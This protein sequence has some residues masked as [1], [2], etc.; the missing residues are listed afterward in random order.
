MFK[1]HQ[2]GIY[3]NRHMPTRKWRRTG[4]N[5]FIMETRSPQDSNHDP[6]ASA[7]EVSRLQKLNN[8]LEDSIAQRT[9]SLRLSQ[10][11]LLDLIESV[12][13]SIFTTDRA[14]RIL[15][16]NQATFEILGYTPSE[17]IGQRFTR[18]LASGFKAF[19]D[20]IKEAAK[21]R[22]V[23]LYA[24]VQVVH[25]DGTTRWIGQNVRFN[26]FEGKL[27]KVQV[28]G[29]D[30]TAQREFDSK[31][32]GSEEKYRGI[33]ENMELGLLEVDMHGIVVRA[34]DH[35]CEMLGYSEEELIGRDPAD[36]LL[37]TKEQ[38]E[39]GGRINERAVGKGGLYEANVLTKSGE[40]KC[41][42]ISAAPVLGTNGEVVGS[43]GIHCDI[44]ARKKNEDALDQARREALAARDAE[45]DFL[46]KMSHEIRTPMNAVVGMAHLLK[47]TGLNKEQREYTEA[48]L[49]AANLLQGLLNSVLDLSKID[50]GA[51]QCK[52]RSGSFQNTLLEVYD[53]FRFILREK[54]VELSL[55]VD[56]ALPGLLKFD[57]G[58]VSQIL[59]NLVGNAVKFTD[60]GK[61]VISARWFPALRGESPHVLLGVS[62]TG[63]GISAGEVPL[64]FERFH[65]VEQAGEFR[66]GSTGLGLSI[67][68][69]LAEIHGGHVSV[70]SDEG[71]G[72]LFEVDLVVHELKMQPVSLRAAPSTFKGIRVLIAED[73]PFN[74]RYI[75][76]LM[77]RW[78]VQ[79]KLVENGLLAVE[80]YANSTWDLVLMDVQMPECD[81]L[82]ATRKIR[83]I[84]AD[85]GART[86]G[87]IGL[88]AFDFDHDIQAAML[89]GMDH[90]IRK[91]YTPDDL[92]NKMRE[93]LGVG[94]EP[95]RPDL[96]RS[97]EHP[98]HTMC[99]G[100]EELWAELQDV[101]RNGWPQLRKEIESSVAENNAK[102]LH[103]ALHKIKPS[104]AMVNLQ[105]AYGRCLSMER[106]AKTGENLPL[107]EVA[108]L[109]D[110][111]AL[112]AK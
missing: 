64:I 13:D 39:M 32:R 30:I 97:P 89:A 88:S 37:A 92:S 77:Q 53:S 48:I 60:S 41:L 7:Q 68:R 18:F 63:V 91:P 20:R 75:T 70:K 31:L 100:D 105:E 47:D 87:I 79:Y 21:R 61:I 85:R 66:S 90:H 109:V 42:L 25:A 27:V 59:L 78:G 81:G 16:A 74:A 83:A 102:M 44:T 51:I 28:V 54:G 46:A 49:H 95:L 17:L 14:G 82:E 23:Q 9:Q 96:V 103:Q 6:D 38:L 45:K 2:Q 57:R 40:E 5:Y 112:W 34:Y 98:V 12:N 72:S 69:E 65:Q 106:R 22:D 93:A 56:P 24:E 62:D 84:E 99:E 80:N 4:V 86:A 3:V 71:E 67:V 33:I 94:G 107:D 108:L 8:A 50:G 52:Y 15:F 101:F 55:D 10:S 43:V 104:L 35:F 36:F 76:R 26:Y 58:I 110:E 111:I 73:N 1:T 19:G 11:E 29:R